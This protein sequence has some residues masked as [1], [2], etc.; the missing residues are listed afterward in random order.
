[1]ASTELI[2]LVTDIPDHRKLYESTLKACGYRVTLTDTGAQAIVYARSA[3]PHCAVI[4]E[5]LP[6]MSGWELCQSIKDDSVL[7]CVPIVMLTQEISKE[8]AAS[9]ARARCNS[10]LARPTAAEDL[11]R[12][13]QYVLDQGTGEPATPNEAIIGINVCPACNSDNIRAGVRVASVQYYCCKEC[14]LCWRFDVSQAPA[15]TPAT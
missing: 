2:L 14:A 15:P 7:K 11:A 4:D 5:R 1:M 10:W 13:V 8:S 3:P 9:G 12:A 6:D